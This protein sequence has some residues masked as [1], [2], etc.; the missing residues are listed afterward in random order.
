MT[1]AA[2][3]D[4]VDGVDLGMGI[5]R[6]PGEA[7]SRMA[8]DVEVQFGGVLASVE[9]LAAEYFVHHV[10]FP[11]PLRRGE[12]HTFGTVMRI[13]DGQQMSAHF[14]YRPHRRIDRLAIRVR[15]GR[16][17]LPRAVWRVDSIRHRL[18]HVDGPTRDV[19]D[20]DSVG[21]VAVSF[22]RLGLGLGYGV[23]WLP[24]LGG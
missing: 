22:E 10:R 16:D 7:R 20:P 9:R 4:G 23:A 1:V 24:R 19:L 15:F 5:P 12:E 2:L 6:P 13:P 11:R 21:E 17:R 3:K 8:L 14:V 18:S